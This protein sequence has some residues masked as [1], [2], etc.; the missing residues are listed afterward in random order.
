MSKQASRVLVVDEDPVT[1]LEVDRQLDALGWDGL[2]VNTGSEAI[3]VVE[4]GLR[5]EVLLTD[6]RLPDLDGRWVAWAVTRLQPSTRL[7]FMGRAAPEAPLEPTNAPFLLKPFSR[8]ALANALTLAV[9][10]PR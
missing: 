5:V 4:L 3:R 10:Y 6:V 2:P 9:R 1:R 8:A 7:V